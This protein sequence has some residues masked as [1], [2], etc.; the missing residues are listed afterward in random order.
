MLNY[1]FKAIDYRF[2]FL[3]KTVMVFRLLDVDHAID[4]Y[5]KCSS[6]AGNFPANKLRIIETSRYCETCEARLFAPPKASLGGK[7]AKKIKTSRETALVTPRAGRINYILN[8]FL[9]WIAA[10]ILLAKILPNAT[11]QYPTSSATMSVADPS[12]LHLIILLVAVVLSWFY[13]MARVKDLGW[14]IVLAFFY[15][16]PGPNFALFIWPGER[17]KNSYGTPPAKPS[18]VKAI[19]AVLLWP[20][21]VVVASKV[22]GV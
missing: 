5:M 18:W 14:P 6:C 3:A 2:D 13:T 4:R 9:A 20:A 7:V 15:C 8:S 1:Y 10:P 16:L 19:I 22:L 12:P 11:S 17:D 21:G